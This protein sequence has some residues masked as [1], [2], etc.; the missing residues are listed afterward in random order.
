MHTCM[1]VLC[2]LCA[3][4]CVRVC[5]HANMVVCACEH[6]VCMRTRCTVCVAHTN[7]HNKSTLSTNIA[8][9][10]AAYCNVESEPNPNPT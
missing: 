2:V 9:R 10:V 8:F 6:G 4:V 3:C 7:E 5:V 1:Y